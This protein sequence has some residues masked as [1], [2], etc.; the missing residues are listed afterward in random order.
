MLTLL[1]LHG[2]PE[3]LSERDRL[4][5]VVRFAGERRLAATSAN[6]WDHAT[7][8]ELAAI[9]SDRAAS[10]RH[11]CDALSALRESWQ[12]RTTARNLA[13]I[14][15]ARAERGTDVEWIRELIAELERK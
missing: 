6:Y 2:D 15:D 12:A 9:A 5:P 10:D 4:V 13:L 8:L 7:M 1:E 14:A 11:L 3:D